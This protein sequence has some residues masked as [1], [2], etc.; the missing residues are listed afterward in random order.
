MHGRYHR[1]LSLHAALA[2]SLPYA[3]ANAAHPGIAD[4][5]LNNLPR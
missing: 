3:S 1:S 4:F 5:D 2:Y